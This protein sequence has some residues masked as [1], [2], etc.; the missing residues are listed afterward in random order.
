MN[1]KNFHIKAIWDEDAGVFYS[2]SDIVGLH[3]E[4]ATIEEFQ[5]VMEENA[6]DLVISNHIE[7]Q[8]LARKKITDLIPTIFWE[9]GQNGMAAA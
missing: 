1:K 7:P 6:L 4:A 5:R 8:E 3:I 2:E 9:R